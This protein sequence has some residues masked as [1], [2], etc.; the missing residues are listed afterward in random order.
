MRSVQR[1]I[2]AVVGILGILIVDGGRGAQAEWYVAGYGGFSTGGDLSDVTMPIRGDRLARQQ[3]PQAD[4]P[5]NVTDS[6]RGILYQHFT[7]SDLSLKSSALYGGKVGY[8][9]TDMKLPWLGV[10]AEV[11]T[12]TPNIKAQTVDTS[13]QITYQP[14]D[15]APASR[16]ADITPP[17]NCPASVVNKSRLALNESD[18]R[19]LTFALNLI[20]RYPGSV[21]QP[22]VGVGVGA[23]YFLSSGQIDGRQFVPGLNAQF[24]LKYLATPHWALFAEGKYNLAHVSTL[25]QTFGISGLYSI[26]HVA[27]GV[28][29][30]F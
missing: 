18:L 23:F 6:G 11:F 12:T 25:D 4:D 16:C 26:F 2:M 14:N 19:V 21:V 15:P 10:E 17:P 1:V 28:A 30:H 22:Y 8:F 5:P 3:F 29:Y 9:F 13:H 27:G 20:A 24:G 7:T